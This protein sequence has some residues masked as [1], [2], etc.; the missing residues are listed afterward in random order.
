MILWA[1]SAK[2]GPTGELAI[3][4]QSPVALPLSGTY[5]AD[6]FL[7]TNQDFKMAITGIDIP[8]NRLELRGRLGAD[9]IVRPGAS[10]FARHPGALHP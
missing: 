1:V 7:L 3:D 5:Q 2:R 6:A 8:F 9:G 10:A 4:P